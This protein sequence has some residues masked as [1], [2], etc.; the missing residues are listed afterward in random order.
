MLDEYVFPPEKNRPLETKKNQISFIIPVFRNSAS[1]VPLVRQLAE[2]MNKID[3]QFEI[4]F[5]DDGSD[6]NSWEIISELTTH[7]PEIRGFRFAKN[8]GQHAAVLFGLHHSQSPVAIVMD[9]DLQDRL[10]AIIVLLN[11]HANSSAEVVFAGRIGSYQSRARMITSNLYRRI[12]LKKVVGLPRGAGMFFL[13]TRPA[14]QKI[15]C[16]KL[17]SG[18]MVIGMVAAAKLSCISVPFARSKRVY[19]KSSYTSLKRLRSAVNMLRC[20]FF[21]KKSSG[22]PLVNFIVSINVSECIT[23]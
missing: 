7:Y 6:D 17:A 5:V 12:L 21:A 10:E 2:T 3:T 4:V 1:L 15:L 13:I 16:L 8:H 19:G 23:H 22:D 11:V 20:A 9:A 18:P 14:F